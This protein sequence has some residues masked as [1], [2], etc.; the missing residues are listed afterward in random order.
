MTAATLFAAIFTNTRPEAI[1]LFFDGVDAFV[2]KR[3]VV[4]RFLGA[5]RLL[6]PEEQYKLYDIKNDQDGIFT[7]GFS[8]ANL[9]RSLPKSWKNISQTKLIKQYVM[10][11]ADYVKNS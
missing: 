9:I 3:E 10:R 6:N 1:E 4:K 5:K 7:Y 8:E 2:I 11:A